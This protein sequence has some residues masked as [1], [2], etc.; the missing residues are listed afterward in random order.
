MSL[1]SHVS[2]LHSVQ[3][4]SRV[5]LQAILTQCSSYFANSFRFQFPLRFLTYSLTFFIP[6]I[7]G[8]FSPS[9]SLCLLDFTHFAS[10]F[11]FQ[12]IV[13]QSTHL[14]ILV[15]SPMTT[16]LTLSQYLSQ[17]EP[18]QFLSSPSRITRYNPNALKFPLHT[19]LLFTLLQNTSSL[20]RQVIVIRHRIHAILTSK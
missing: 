15:H 2:Q 7:V 13:S 8:Y 1:Y 16:S 4:Y 19:L 9:I 6:T 18:I 3:L 11:Q 12:I 5:P 17:F 20:H 14:Y 10:I